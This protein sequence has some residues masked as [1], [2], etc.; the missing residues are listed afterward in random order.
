MLK[1]TR[2]STP[3]IMFIPRAYNGPWW[4]VIVHG[5][6]VDFYAGPYPTLLCYIGR[7]IWGGRL[8][9]FSA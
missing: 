6:F 4:P 8:R 2:Y 7:S 3:K 1:L 5:E 9:R